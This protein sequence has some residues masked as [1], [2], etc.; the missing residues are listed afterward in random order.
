MPNP[1]YKEFVES[2]VPEEIILALLCNY[3]GTEPHDII[4]KILRSLYKITGNNIVIQKYLNILLG[5]E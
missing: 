3:E 2:N 4:S 1:S 5:I